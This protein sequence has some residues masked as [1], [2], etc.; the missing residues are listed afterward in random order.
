MI[1][2]GL[3]G[4][5]PAPCQVSEGKGGSSASENREGEELEGCGRKV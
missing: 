1:R 3:V 2:R 4:R 5:T